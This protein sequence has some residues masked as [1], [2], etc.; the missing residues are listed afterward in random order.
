MAGIKSVRTAELSEEA[1]REITQLMEAAFGE[2]FEG[3]W[4]DIGAALHFMALESEEVLAHA[5]VVDRE[6]HTQ[7]HQLRTGYVEGVAA[8][9]DR[10]GQ[11]HST[12]VMQAVNE[13]LVEN[14]QLGGLSTG[15]NGFYTKL[16]WETWRGRTYIRMRD[17]ALARTA[18]EDGTVM[19]LKTKATPALNTKAH[20]SAEWRPGELW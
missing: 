8:W 14:Y 6:L 13:F 18:E 1:L 19:I 11:G 10:Q 20:I 15:V 9:P 12:K 4:D 16:G 7:G 17:G 2:S 5:C 3:Y